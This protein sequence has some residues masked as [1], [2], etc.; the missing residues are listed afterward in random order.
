MAGTQ[1]GKLLAAKIRYDKL[2]PIERV[3]Q[4]EKKGFLNSDTI[5]RATEIQTEMEKLLQITPKQL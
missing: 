2:Q 3:E 5:E 4:L 1:E